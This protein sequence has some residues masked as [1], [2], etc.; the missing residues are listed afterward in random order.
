MNQKNKNHYVIIMAGGTGTRFWP[1]SR[2]NLPKQFLDILGVGKTLLQQTYSRFLKEFEANNIYIVTNQ[3]Y[4]SLVKEQIPDIPDHCLLGEPSAKNT[5][6]CISFASAK[7]HR[8]NTHA[9]CVVAPSDHLILN[10]QDFQMNLSEA[11]LYA[12]K[13]NA[14]ITLGIRPSR[15]DTGYGYIQFNPEQHE[16]HKIYRVKTFT[17]KP[18][19]E[20]A[21]TFIESG[22]F[23]WNSG[24]FVWSVS[25]INDAFKQYMPEQFALFK[26]A[27]KSFGTS[28]ELQEV[29]AAYEQCRSVS[30][31][32]GVMEKADNVFVIPSEFGWSDLGTWTSL[33]ENSEKDQQGNVIRGKNVMVYDAENCLINS[34][35]GKNRLV[36]VKSAKNLIVV[37]TADVTLICDMSMEQE[38][39]Q[40]VTDMKLKFEDKFT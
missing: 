17:E 19:A 6:A 28:R 14:L 40:I 15:P 9:V 36:V 13:H 12:Q 30:I 39:R 38:V 23:L 29:Q 37:D 26:E 18:T 10:E 2:V 27:A 35:S 32:Y 34:N 7:I 33:Y 16:E 31:D 8:K 21:R 25:A 11:L 5:A 20:I 22:E 3:S 24:I 4:I 1:F